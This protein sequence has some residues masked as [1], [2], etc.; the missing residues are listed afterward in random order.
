MRILELQLKHFG[1]FDQKRVTF[2]DGINVICG[3]NEM[4]KTTMHSFIRAMLFGIQRG[5][6]RAAKQDE[7]SLRQPWENGT[8]YEGVLRLESGGKIFRLE[9]NF[10]KKDKM[11]NLICETDGEELSLED[12]D[13]DVLLEGMSQEAFVNTVFIRQEGARTQQGLAEELRG[14]MNNLQNA[15]DGRIHVNQALAF[16][17]KRQKD[18][19]AERKQQLAGN[20]RQAQEM[21][22]RL[23]YASQ[24]LEQCRQEL[25]EFKIRTGQVRKELE[26]A[27][28]GRAVEKQRETKTKQYF[29]LWILALVTLLASIFV[30]G[31][32]LKF[33]LLLAW[34][35]LFGLFLLGRNRPNKEKR[36]RDRDPR[37]VEKMEWEEERLLQE[38][39]EKQTLRD[40]LL[41]AREEML[42]QQAKQT[43]WE[44]DVNALRMASEAIRSLAE[45]I[46]RESARGLNE[47]ISQILSEITG[48]KYDRVFLDAHMQVKIHTSEKLLGLEQISRGTM[49]QVYFALRMAAGELLSG[50][51]PMPIIL[52][53]AFV[54]YDDDRLARTLEWMRKSGRQ[55]ILFTCQSREKRLLEKSL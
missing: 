19:E 54:M 21:Q 2:H 37:I 31:I 53:D 40:N 32:G 38:Q 15:G 14:F 20:T 55:V 6:G 44:E 18:L 12:G 13:L 11:A 39:K 50:G 3:E 10:Y 9:R 1:K 17:E 42:A 34:L 29:L 22:M 7:Y 48:G 26:Y 16:L 24:E 43:R 46:Y 25:E 47:R 5:R 51:A 4:G 36:E 33:V 30:P 23:D 45:E 27:R 28:R 8:Y 35:F 52:D 49:E 41:E